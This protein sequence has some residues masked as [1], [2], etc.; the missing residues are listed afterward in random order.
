MGR[1]VG[2]ARQLVLAHALVEAALVVPGQIRQLVLAYKVQQAM[3]PI[4]AMVGV[5]T[6]AALAALER[7]Q[8]EHCELALQSLKT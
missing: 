3:T 6:I 1:L 2:L 7:Q 8:V 5:A 4:Q